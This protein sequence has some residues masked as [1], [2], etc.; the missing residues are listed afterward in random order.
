MRDIMIANVG[1][2]APGFFVIPELLEID[3]LPEQQQQTNKPSRRPNPAL[4]E[5][6]D[7]E[8]AAITAHANKKARPDPNRPT[9]PVPQQPAQQI[10]SQEEPS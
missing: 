7:E 10:R 1:N 2:N 9:A 8:I 5:S 6:E 3:E 4:S